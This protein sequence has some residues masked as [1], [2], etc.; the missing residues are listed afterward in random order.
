MAGGLFFGV[1]LYGGGEE[2]TQKLIKCHCS[3][4][5]IATTTPQLTPN[6]ECLSAFLINDRMNLHR[7][8][9]NTV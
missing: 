6:M 7:F 8:N 4:G 3:G 9:V 5:S 1:P 2:K